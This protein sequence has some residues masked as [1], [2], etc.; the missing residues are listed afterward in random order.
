MEGGKRYIIQELICHCDY[1]H[2]RE[3]AVTTT[4]NLQ[5]GN[6]QT[7]LHRVSIPPLP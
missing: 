6:L 3:P 1:V 4:H 7:I 5:Y 2:T